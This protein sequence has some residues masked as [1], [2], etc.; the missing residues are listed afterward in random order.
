MVVYTDY[1]GLIICTVDYLISHLA[2]QSANKTPATERR[3]IQESDIQV[4]IK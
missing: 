4:E 1:W 2:V 3:L